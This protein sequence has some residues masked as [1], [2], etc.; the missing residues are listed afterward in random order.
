M[1]RPA[2]TILLAIAAILTPLPAANPQ[3]KVEVAESPEP[4]QLQAGAQELAVIDLTLAVEE[5]Q[6][7]R[8]QLIHNEALAHATGDP[9]RT[10]RR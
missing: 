9:G 3:A 8:R 7:T 2:L 6:R 5:Y 4:L 1:K 10:V